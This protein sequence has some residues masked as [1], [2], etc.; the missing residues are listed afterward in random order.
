MRYVNPE[1]VRE[2]LPTGWEQRAQQAESDVSAAQPQQRSAEVNKRSHIWKELKDTLKK[3]SHTK[4]WYCESIDSRSDNA[5][6][7]F[8]P[9]NA[10]A[11]CPDHEG[12]WWLAFRW[13]NYRFCCTCCNSRRVDQATG[14]GGG[15]ANHF[16]LKDEG[17]RAKTPAHDLANEEPLLL[18]PTVSGD[19]G[20]LWYDETGRAM[21]NPVC[22]TDGESYPHNRARTSIA[23]YHLNHTD[24]VERR[25]ALCLDTRRRVEEA[26]RYF[27]QYEAGDGTAR[28]AFSDAV[29][30]LQNRVK[31]NA[32]YSATA[33]AMLMGLRGKHP[34]VDVILLA[35]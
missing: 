8:R 24:V 5:V 4:C 6:D 9:K 15:K 29:R 7:H 13:E 3:A 31:V 1:L 32:E 34:V 25:K 20:L 10:V 22:G 12:Y 18:D 33:R 2:N 11:E 26:D 30:D 19:A 14:Q 23:L 35:A 27:G 28:Q 17:N 16:P 21:P